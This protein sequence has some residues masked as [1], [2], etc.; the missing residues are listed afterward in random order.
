M[1]H[2]SP[3]KFEQFGTELV[4]LAPRREDAIGY[5]EG[6]AGWLYTVEFCGRIASED[7]V[8]EAGRQAGYEG[9]YA[10]EALE[11]YPETV[12][13]LRSLGYHGAEYEDLGPNNAY[14]HDTVMLFGPT[15]ARIVAV[16]EIPDDEEEEA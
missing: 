8:L 4:C 10:W 9:T 3:N 12:A 1:Y 7:E 2:A 15:L 5:L 11:E 6:Y 14:E 16:D 13:I